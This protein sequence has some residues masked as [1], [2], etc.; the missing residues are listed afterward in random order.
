MIFA[1]NIEF[2]TITNV[3]RSLDEA[4]VFFCNVGM[5]YHDEPV[6]MV[7]YCARPNDTAPTCQWVLEQISQGNF[8]GEIVDVP[9]GYDPTTMEP[10]V[11][12]AQPISQGSQTL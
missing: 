2:T 1:G 6:E 5:S 8:E 3:R 11:V 12:I 9:N 7:F 4:G 10:W